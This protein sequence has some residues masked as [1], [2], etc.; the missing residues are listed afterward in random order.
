MSLADEMRWKYID[1][2]KWKAFERL[3]LEIGLMHAST[4]NL[5]CLVE[6]PTR[7]ARI[8]AALEIAGLIAF[9]VMAAKP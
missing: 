6:A 2:P 1:A 4:I 9:A 8:A 7:E 3:W 5:M